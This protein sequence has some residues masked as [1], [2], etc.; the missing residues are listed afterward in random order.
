MSDRGSCQPN[1]NTTGNTET[2]WKA[3][4]QKRFSTSVTHP[5]PLSRAFNQ[6]MHEPTKLG[7]SWRFG[8]GAFSPPVHP[9]PLSANHNRTPPDDRGNCTLLRHRSPSFPFRE[10]MHAARTYQSRSLR[11]AST[12]PTHKIFIQISP[13]HHGRDSHPAR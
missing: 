9:F 7:T 8:D 5:Q 12:S 3:R 6:R 13:T 4:A 1:P 11:M 2:K 10:E